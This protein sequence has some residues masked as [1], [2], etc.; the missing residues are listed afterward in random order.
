[1]AFQESSGRVA[2]PWG[3]HEV[4]VA[5]PGDTAARGL[6]VV[7]DTG[8]Y[9]DFA[10]ASV[11]RLVRAAYLLTGNREDA[12]DLA[13]DVLERVFVAWPRIREH[14]Y[15]YAHRALVNH[16]H[17]H[18]RWRRRHPEAELTLVAEPVRP[19]DTRHV[20]DHHVLVRALQQL[21]PKQRTVL[22]LRYFEDMSEQDTATAMGTSVGTV[23][24]Q[25]SKAIAALR[26]LVPDG[27]EERGHT[28]E[29]AMHTADEEQP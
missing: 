23:K 9:D 8:T 17:N 4:L 2:P 19:D 5:R 15:A 18:R 14:P 13:Q 1:M 28:E 6:S 12:N 27:V 25:S 24:S 22:V 11:T 20:L 29:R 10:A 3:D 21:P 7:S 16:A 26:T